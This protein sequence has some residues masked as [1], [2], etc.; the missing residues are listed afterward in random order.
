[1]VI[2]YQD[3]SDINYALQRSLKLTTQRLLVGNTD[4]YAEYIDYIHEK[5]KKYCMQFV[6]LL[7]SKYIKVQTFTYSDSGVTKNAKNL[8]LIQVVFSNRGLCFV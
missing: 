1:M 7:S 2:H 5:F 6:I 4:P 3:V 8:V